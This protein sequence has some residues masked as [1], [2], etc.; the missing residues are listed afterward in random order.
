MVS[1]LLL[2]ICKENTRLELFDDIYLS[3]KTMLLWDTFK[4]FQLQMGEAISDESQTENDV[5]E[6]D[7]LQNL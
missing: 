3:I 7:S 4:K 2:K 6:S 5:S 1:D